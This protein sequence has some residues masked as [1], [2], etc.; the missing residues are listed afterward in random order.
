MAVQALDDVDEAKVWLN[1]PH[2]L[3]GLA[4]PIDLAATDLGARQVERI[5]HNIEHGLPV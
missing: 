4:W 1:T 5:L 3:L 2:P